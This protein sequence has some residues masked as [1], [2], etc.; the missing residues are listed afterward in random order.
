MSGGGGGGGDWRPAAKGPAPKAEGGTKGDE[1]Q[2][3][4]PEPCNILETTNLNS[5]DRTV[6]A[7][8][9][10]GDRLPVEY[11][12]GPPQR[13]VAKSP[14]GVVAGSITSPSM[15]QIIRCIQDGYG[16]QAVVLAIRGAQCQV[17]V[18]PR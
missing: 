2:Q 14:S 9:R 1:G 3:A 8:L 4:P 12:S 13:L 5:V 16:Y 6:L 10:P 7:G 17:R 11:E 18:E 15:V